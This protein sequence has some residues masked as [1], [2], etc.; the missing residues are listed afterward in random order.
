VTQ[1]PQDVKNLKVV[2]VDRDISRQ[3]QHYPEG[4]TEEDKQALGPTFSE[5]R[6][7]AQCFPY[8]YWPIISA[9]LSLVFLTPV[10]ILGLL[11]SFSSD[12]NEEV[13]YLPTILTVLFLFLIVLGLTVYWS[14]ASTKRYRMLLAK[15]CAIF[16]HSKNIGQFN[17]SQVRLRPGEGGKWIEA[18]KITLEESRMNLI[19]VPQNYI[20]GHIAS[21]QASNSTVIH[22]PNAPIISTQQQI[23]PIP[24]M[25]RSDSQREALLPNPYGPAPPR[26]RGNMSPFYI[27]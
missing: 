16:C 20:P 6:S 25:E 9:S 11:L 12:G 15:A 22:Y 24:G 1:L 19:Q 10:I 26:V 3:I 23:N 18:H 21:T 2:L 27:S 7:L 14:V 17:G 8:N 13:S 5:F 4:F